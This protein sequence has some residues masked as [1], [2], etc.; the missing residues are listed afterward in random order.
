MTIRRVAYVLKVFP[1][2]SETFIAAELAE[3]RRRGIEVRILSLL[4]ERGGL[5]HEIVANAGLEQLTS[6]EP[7]EFLAVLRDFQPQ[8]IHAHFATEATAAAIELAEE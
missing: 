3:V 2:L 1:K 7:K 4:P 8:L 5:K 6:Y